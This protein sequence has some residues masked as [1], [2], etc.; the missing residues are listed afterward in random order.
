MSECNFCDVI[1][2]YDKYVLGKSETEGVYYSSPED[3]YYLILEQLRYES[4][5]LEIHCCPICGSRLGEK[6]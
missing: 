3:K 6:K 5:I 1:N 2:D 4:S